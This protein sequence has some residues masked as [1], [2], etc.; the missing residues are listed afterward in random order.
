MDGP[1]LALVLRRRRIE[2]DEASLVERENRLIEKK[3]RLD[4]LAVLL[5]IREREQEVR[6][7][8]LTE[9]MDTFGR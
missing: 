3:R 7:R 4:D 6:K 2:A 8:E 1:E 5:D 9:A